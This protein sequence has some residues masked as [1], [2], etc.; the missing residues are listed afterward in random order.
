M[1]A[2]CMGVGGA[3]VAGW[4]CFSFVLDS[5]RLLWSRLM[6]SFGGV[7]L[8]RWLLP[9]TGKGN[10]WVLLVQG[11]HAPDKPL[12]GSRGREWCTGLMDNP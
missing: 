3:P 2:E 9:C 11:P 12:V 10:K 7:N 8:Y 4:V 5:K 6:A 1:L